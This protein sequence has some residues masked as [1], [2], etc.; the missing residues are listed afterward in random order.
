MQ[1]LRGNSRWYVRVR[2]NSW[3]DLSGLRDRWDTPLSLSLSLAKISR[4]FRA[5]IT[6][7][8]TFSSLHERAIDSTFS[9]AL[10]YRRWNLTSLFNQAKLSHIQIS[11]R[12]ASTL[13]TTLRQTRLSFVLHPDLHFL[14]SR[15]RVTP[16][17]SC[18]YLFQ[19][20]IQ[21][22][23]LT[24]ERLLPLRRLFLVKHNKKTKRAV[25]SPRETHLVAF[26]DS[27]KGKKNRVGCK[28]N[29]GTGGM[30]GAARVNIFSGKTC[31]TRGG[32]SRVRKSAK[33]DNTP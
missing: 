20:A 32:G 29:K 3:C 25:V 23:H 2:H 7:F 14:L 30:G 5:R 16:L 22:L 21:N 8:L 12:R 24:L 17:S 6:F 28:H 9:S 13:R 18:A 1:S 19:L 11:S 4:V 10:I 26:S 15:Y 27:E 31:T 33:R